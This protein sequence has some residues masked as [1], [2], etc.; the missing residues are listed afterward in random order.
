MS[1]AVLDW[2]I[3]GLGFYRA[4]KA[5]LPD[6]P[7]VYLSDTGFEPYGLVPGPALQRRLA[8]TAGRLAEAGAS[9]L[10]VA[11]NAMSTVLPAASGLRELGFEQVCGVIDGGVAATLDAGVRVVGVIGGRRTV[12][13]GCYAHRL[14]AAGLVVR[15][16]VAQPLS[17]LIEAGL[18]ASPAFETESARIVAP[19]AGVDA[20]VLGCTHY[21]AAAERLRT[22]AGGALLI[23]PAAATLERVVLGWYGVPASGDGRRG[24]AAAERGRGADSSGGSSIAWSSV[25]PASADRFFT[26]GDPTA[27][28]RAAR[29]G[30]GVELPAVER[31]RLRATGSV[32]A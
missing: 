2:G 4:F 27:M 18:V 29:L 13:S 9:R 11:C 16:R 22:L 1:L 17:G 14:R 24:G 12:R 20:L 7:V 32:P 25:E 21:E 30:F 31:V 23:D 28:V 6:V 15:Q 19:L 3:G 10:V 5:R 26:T 8:L